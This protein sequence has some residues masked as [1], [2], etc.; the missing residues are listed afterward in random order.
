MSK[1]KIIISNSTF[2][3]QRVGVFAGHGWDIAIDS[4]TIESLDKAVHL[5]GEPS[6]AD[7]LGLSDLPPENLDKFIELLKSGSN[8]DDAANKSGVAAYLKEHAIE[9][10]TFLTNLAQLYKG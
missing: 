3:G 7:Q 1:D 6:V 4:T 8:P 5:A 10:A 2:K 9:F